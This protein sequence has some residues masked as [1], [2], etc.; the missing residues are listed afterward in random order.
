MLPAGRATLVDL[1]AFLRAVAERQDLARASVEIVNSGPPGSLIGGLSSI[2]PN[3][4]Q[5]FDVPLR[6]PGPVNQSTGSYPWRLDGDYN[7]IITVTNVAA[8][9]AIFVAKITYAGGSVQ[10]APR[11]LAAGET[12]KFDMRQLRDSGAAGGLPSTE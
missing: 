12:A 6:E 10:P 4:V 3:G 1:S 7:T 11:R 8:T 9:P 5:S 2:T